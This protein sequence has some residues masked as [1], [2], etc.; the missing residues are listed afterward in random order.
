V[1]K[2][3][4]SSVGAVIAAPR[5]K[6]FPISLEAKLRILV[7]DE[8]LR[9]KMGLAGRRRYEERF[10]AAITMRQIAVLYQSLL[11]ARGIA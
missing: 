1:V 7:A 5:K 8:D 9:K 2:R 10:S 6:E 3:G 4:D 11:M